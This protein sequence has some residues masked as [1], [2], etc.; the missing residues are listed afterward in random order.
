MMPAAAL[1]LHPV[2]AEAAPA[3]II[4][5]RHGEKGG[6]YT[7]C[8]VGQARGQ[9]LAAYYLGRNAQKSLFRPGETP[10]AILAISMHTLDTI[11]PV[12]ESW[13][14]PV[15]YYSV[16]PQLKG[17]KLVLSDAQ[18]NQRTR[19]A[20]RDI[21]EKPEWVG[22]TLVV[23][24]EHD[25]IAKT[26][27]DAELP[28]GVP[29]GDRPAPTRRDTLYDLLGLEHLAGV[30]YN[31]PRNTYDYFWIIDFDPATGRPAAFSMVKQAFGPP[32][33]GLPSNDWGQ[34]NGLT[35]ADGCTP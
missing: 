4:L 28:A 1:T 33:A 25:H 16:M 26:R 13:N 20:A 8:L 14:M 31:W 2:A 22:Q 34:P 23:D 18:L 12:A 7:L 35:A 5:L 3:R 17:G 32:F 27:L 6:P 19:E 30:P 10:R 11:A 9:A 24:W 29:R 15:I 21:L